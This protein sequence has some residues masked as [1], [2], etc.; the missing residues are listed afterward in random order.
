MKLIKINESQKKRLF[1]AYREGF[2]LKELSAL[3]NN[4]WGA[5][6]DY[7]VK[8]LGEPNGFGSSRCVF[9]LSDN[10]IL[11]L[12]VGDQYQAGI[13]QNKQEYEMYETWDSPLLVRIY[14][15]DKNFTFL[16]CESVVPAERIDFEQILGLP[17]YRC[18]QGDKYN[19]DGEE[20]VGYDE[21]FDKLKNP[22]EETKI[23]VYNILAYI[24]SNYVFH[25]PYHDE[26]IEKAIK[27]SEW[28]SQFR[29]FIMRTGMPD[30]CQI[31]NFGLVNRN[32]NPTLVILDSG[33]SLDIWN[34][35]YAN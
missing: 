23:N 25:E 10:L 6:Y 27:N 33:F 15:V 2:S 9:T 18:V 7:C 28:L 32:G 30:F 35:Y 14:N 13:A 20:I 19:V 31:G 29:N 1:E 8:L 11:K 5:Q 4:G 3:G 16:I 17:F 21:Y 34:K 12:A 26:K 24:E 22:D